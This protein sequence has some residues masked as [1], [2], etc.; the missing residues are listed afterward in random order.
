[1]NARLF[2]RAKDPSENAG[3]LFTKKIFQRYL[4]CYATLLT[5]TTM[6][7]GDDH[8]EFL[9]NEQAKWQSLVLEEIARR[10]KDPTSP[11]I[12][13]EMGKKLA[14]NDDE[15][16]A[17]VISGGVLNFSYKVFPRK[18]PDQAEVYA[19]LSL[20]F[21]LWNTDKLPV[22]ID[23]MLAEFQ[24]L[25]KFTTPMEQEESQQQQQ[26]QQ[27]RQQQYAPVA[28]PLFC[29]HLMDYAHLLV[30]EWV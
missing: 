10:F 4:S 9:A 23:R 2:D 22:D 30:M 24:M 17:T 3:A 11:Q 14:D 20:S 6:R 1:L 28:L 29:T 19:K 13:A 21:A 8:Q 18:S 27:Q 5:K 25:Q 15:L 7:N 16:S 12:L 26:Q